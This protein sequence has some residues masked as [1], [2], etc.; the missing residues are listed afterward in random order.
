MTAYCAEGGQAPPSQSIGVPGGGA[1]REIIHPSCPPLAYILSLIRPLPARRQYCQ[2]HEIMS[3]RS[4]DG[5]DKMN[6]REPIADRGVSAGQLKL[7]SRDRVALP[8][9]PAPASKLLFLQFFIGLPALTSLLAIPCLVV[10]TLPASLV[11]PL[12]PRI[13]LSL[14]VHL[15]LIDLSRRLSR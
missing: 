2:V 9:I 11:S 5:R 4:R 1:T 6:A 15:S 8:I 7:G 12:S 13:L 3:A 10:F 14:P